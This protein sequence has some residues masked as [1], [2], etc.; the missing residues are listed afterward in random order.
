MLL[1]I[2]QMNIFLPRLRLLWLFHLNTHFNIQIMYWLAL[3]LA[4]LLEILS[5]NCLTLFGISIGVVLGL[6]LVNY[7]DTSIG[8]LLYYPVYLALGTPIG[9]MMRTLLVNF[10]GR[11]LEAFLGFPL[12]FCLIHLYRPCLNL[13]LDLISSGLLWTSHLGQ[14]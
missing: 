8:S 13:I 9:T 4:R 12:Y 1:H 7:F 10:M 2:L 6:E 11:S 3:Y 5:D 14:R